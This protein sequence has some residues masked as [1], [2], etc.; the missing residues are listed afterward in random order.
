MAF[1]APTLES[2]LHPTKQA[3]LASLL[4]DA[5]ERW[6]WRREPLARILSGPLGATV[7]SAAGHPAAIAALVY[8]ACRPDIDTR[9]AVLLED[10]T[11]EATSDV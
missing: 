6:G 7:C 10:L 9:E 3:A 5:A 8:Y 11:P 1:D 2:V 4:A